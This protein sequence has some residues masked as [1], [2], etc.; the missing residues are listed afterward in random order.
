MSIFDAIKEIP[1]DN[2]KYMIEFKSMFHSDY[3]GIVLEDI[4]LIQKIMECL[5]FHKKRNRA[6]MS[7]VRLG[8]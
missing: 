3:Y 2:R 8:G 7:R 4:Q 1:K 5:E 6:A